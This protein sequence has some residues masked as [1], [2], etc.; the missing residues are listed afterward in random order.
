MDKK[1]FKLVAYMKP[2]GFV[3]INN[4]IDNRI[5]ALEM[6]G[7]YDFIKEQYNETFWANGIAI[8]SIISEKALLIK[9]TLFNIPNIEQTFNVSN[10]LESLRKQA[11]QNL[12][13]K[14]NVIQNLKEK[15]NV[16]K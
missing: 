9:G 1:E 10:L 16:K 14:L 12:K 6:I 7:I 8:H 15:L 4:E 13:E 11:I 3:K 5:N 2:N